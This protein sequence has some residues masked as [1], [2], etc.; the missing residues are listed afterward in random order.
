MPPHSGLPTPCL[1]TMPCLFQSPVRDLFCQFGNCITV[2]C[3]A[4][5]MFTTILA[6]FAFSRL[7]FPGAGS[8][9]SYAFHDDDSIQMLI[10]TN[11]STIVGL[12]LIDTLPR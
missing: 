3:V 10:I 7:K 2:A 4:T 11:Y 1:R 12:G 5:T 9:F 8:V 6:A